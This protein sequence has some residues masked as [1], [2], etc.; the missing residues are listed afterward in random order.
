[1][2]PAALMALLMGDLKNSSLASTPGGIEAQEA[3]GQSAICNT[4]TQETQLLPIEGGVEF[5]KAN[6]F[7]ITNLNPKRLFI[8]CKLPAGWKITPTD[9]SMWSHV[10]DE[11]GTKRAEIFYKAAFY[12]ERAFLSPTNVT[13]VTKG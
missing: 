1:M 3:A 5:C 13:A 6:G 4:T 12:D 7:E 8:E 2:N 11:Q 10:Y 9:H